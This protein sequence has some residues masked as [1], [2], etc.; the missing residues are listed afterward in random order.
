MKQLIIILLA[1]TLFSACKENTKQKPETH[2][3]QSISKTDSVSRSPIKVFT[4][5]HDSTSIGG[6]EQ[7]TKLNKGL[8]QSFKENKDVLDEQ[9]LKESLDSY[10]RMGFKKVLARDFENNSFVKATQTHVSFLAPEREGT[11]G[12]INLEE[13]HFE[14]EAT[15]ISCFE[16]LTTYR[17]REI[18]YKVINW[19]FVRKKNK[20]F[21]IFGFH[22]NVDSEPMRTVKQHLIDDLKGQGEYEVIEI[23]PKRR[24][25]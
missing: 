1:I 14:D 10:E 5:I 16:S 2:L 15:A 17:E 20:L 13:W 4:I 18:Y 11:T 23:G 19:I 25:S 3:K 21:L 8:D 12:T 6:M 7:L 22:F 9:W 24:P